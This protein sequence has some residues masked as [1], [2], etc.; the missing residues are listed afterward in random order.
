MLGP[1][2]SVVDDSGRIARQDVGVDVPV[3]EVAAIGEIAHRLL[4]IL[5]SEP[6][7]QR[8]NDDVGGADEQLLGRVELRTSTVRMRSVGSGAA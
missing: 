5:A 8:G 6:R 2:G 3:D 4:Q 7:R 1:F